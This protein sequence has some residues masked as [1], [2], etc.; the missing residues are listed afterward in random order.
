MVSLCLNL[1]AAL[2]SHRLQPPTTSDGAPMETPHTLAQLGSSVGRL[3][4]GGG[5]AA[6]APT[7]P[8]LQ[9]R[10][11]ARLLRLL[12]RGVDGA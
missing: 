7:D 2:S 11:A 3:T 9:A 8:A 4:D 6:N 12:L 1:P 5:V 10:A